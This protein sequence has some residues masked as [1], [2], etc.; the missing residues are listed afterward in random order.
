MNQ[1]L[2]IQEE[3]LRT[4]FGIHKLI[5]LL[6]RHTEK[7]I[8]KRDKYWVMRFNNLLKTL[9]GSTGKTYSFLQQELNITQQKVEIS[10]NNQFSIN[11]EDN[12]K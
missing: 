3:I 12:K 1:T 4:G 11:T 10:T 7:D 8:S 9:E 5:S 6:E 2:E